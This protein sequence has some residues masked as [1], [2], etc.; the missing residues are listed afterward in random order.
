MK[1]DL[2][3]YID[4][5]DSNVNLETLF[6]FGPTRYTMDKYILFSFFKISIFIKSH[7]KLFYY[8]I[9]QFHQVKKRKFCYIFDSYFFPFNQIVSITA[10]RER[11]RKKNWTPK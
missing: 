6:F 3:K 11:V 5:I 2:W 9:H 7:D 1:I 10:K 4:Y 8:G